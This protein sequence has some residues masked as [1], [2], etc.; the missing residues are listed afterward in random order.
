MLEAHKE[1]FD[2]QSDS[3]LDAFDCRFYLKKLVKELVNTGIAGTRID[4]EFYWVTAEWLCR[5]WPESLCIRWNEPFGNRHKLHGL[6]RSLLPY[7][8]LILLDGV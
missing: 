1:Q 5:Y 3:Y 8:E 7:A 4:Y 2:E 6:L